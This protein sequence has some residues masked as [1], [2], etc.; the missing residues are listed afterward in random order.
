MKFGLIFTLAAGASALSPALVT[1]PN[2]ILFNGLG[3]GGMA[4]IITS[5]P[6]ST[7]SS[8]PSVYSSIPSVSTSSNPIST[9]TST[10]SVST[11]SNPISTQTSTPSVSPYPQSPNPYPQSSTPTPNKYPKPY[12]SSTPTPNEYPK[13]Y[14]QSSN[15]YSQSPNSVEAPLISVLCFSSMAIVAVKGKGNTRMKDIT[16]GDG[17]LTGNGN[18]ETVYSIAHQD[19]TKTSAFLQMY[20][21]SLA[22]GNRMMNN[23]EPIELSMKH[24]VFLVGNPHPIPAEMVK[25]GNNLQTIDGPRTV[26]KIVLVIRDGVY[27]LLTESGT[28]VVNGVVSSTYSTFAGSN[29]WIEVHNNS[30]N[31]KKKKIITAMSHQDFFNVVLQPYKWVCTTFPS[32]E[33]FCSNTNNE[34]KNR[35]GE[36]KAWIVHVAFTVW[37]CLSEQS[38]TI[39]AVSLA[40][41]IPFV[42]LLSI[43]DGVFNN[44]VFFFTVIMISYATT[45]N[46]AVTKKKWRKD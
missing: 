44:A 25:L 10:P 26:T 11:S 8:I 43:L 24:M 5:A 34:S 7:S 30:D 15:P 28:I 13:P 37:N 36:G 32:L 20:S 22:V 1:R 19:K 42:H 41:A 31:N 33:F 6:T 27:S 38:G 16:V 46:G 9:Q 21:S 39:Q 2:T 45:K 23:H 14:S 12:S 4:D 35:G 3:A 40:F 17:V 18:Y 29:E